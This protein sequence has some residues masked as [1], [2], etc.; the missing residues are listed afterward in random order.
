MAQIWV[1]EMDVFGKPW[2][3][4]FLLILTHFVL[5][6][7][8]GGIDDYVFS[9]IGINRD[10]LLLTLWILPI[11]ASYVASR[12]SKKYKLLMGLSYIILFPLIGAIVTYVN[13]ELGVV[14]TEFVG[15]PGAMVMFKLYLAVG[16]ILV[17]LGT[18]LGLVFSK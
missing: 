15:V 8:I 7:L 12:Y 6:V 14:R 2:S 13:G 10:A 17:I 18:A 3:L 5:G 1:D 4:G 11:L 9:R 16:S